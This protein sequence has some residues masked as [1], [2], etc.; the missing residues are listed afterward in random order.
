[1]VIF[2]IRR[3]NP[4]KDRAPYYKDYE[5]NV[6]EGATVLDCLNLIKWTQDGT[7]THRMSCRSAI[8]GSCAV[9]V[10]GHPKL[11][12]K[13]QAVD[14]IINGRMKIEPLGNAKVLKDLVVDLEPFFSKFQKVK[15]WLVTDEIPPTPTLIKGDEGG[16]KERR[17]SSEDFHRI[18]AASTCIMCASCCSDCNSWASNE[19]FLG[20][21]A[22]AKAQRFVDDS[23]DKVALERVINLSKADGIW[24]C[25]HCGECVERCPTEVKPMDRIVS[26]RTT[27]LKMGIANNNGAR[28]VEGFVDSIRSSGR[29]NEN[30]IPVKSMGIFN[31]PG[32]L[33][34]IPVGIRMFL[35]G[36]NPPIIHKHIDDMDDVKRIFKRFG[37]QKG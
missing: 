26:L 32:L 24:D 1:M 36:K 35:R 29:L 17:Q 2:S 31:I 13:T 5:M 34:L 7:L 4:E 15:P 28:H 22:L 25:T 21:A 20:P 10:N 8:C 14:E 27:A 19:N 30:I 6:P 33:S 3:F 16:F 11:A 9:K 18:D 37:K 12:C 23:R